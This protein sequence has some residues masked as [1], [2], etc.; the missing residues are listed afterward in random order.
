M[1]PGTFLQHI[2]SIIIGNGFLRTISGI[3]I[4]DLTEDAGN[5]L[6]TGTT[7][8]IAAVETNAFAVVQAASTTFLGELT[9]TIPW[10]YD[11]SQDHL[12]FNIFC[13]SAGDTDTPTIDATLYR[14]RDSAA[15]SSDL[16]P[17]ISA[18]VN[19]NT[20]N[21]DRV[22]VDAT[23]LDFQGGDVIQLRLITSAHT[24]DALNV[25]A[26][27]VEYRSTLVYADIGSP[28]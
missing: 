28:R 6:T 27:D 1:N 11:I 13:Q 19:T 3:S 26:I 8:P 2:Q 14:K 22:T 20:A 7:P 25:F 15:L 17:T 24:T 12:K 16:D 18:A 23:G 9:F 4:R 10:D 5:L 21:A